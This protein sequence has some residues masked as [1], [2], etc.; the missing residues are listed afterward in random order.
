MIR[1]TPALVAAGLLL[2]ATPVALIGLRTLPAAAPLPIAPD[3]IRPSPAAALD[4]AMARSLFM[5]GAAEDVAEPEEA[6]TADTG[7]A[8][9]LVGIVGRLPDR[10]VAMVRRASGGTRTLAPGESV[11]G[12]R[13]EALSAGA[14]LFVK[15]DRRVR[16]ELPAGE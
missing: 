14:A 16:V 8:P 6:D 5:A 13:I 2:V 4:R 3:P 9:A 15:G 7:D 10:A 1:V 12:W 11:D